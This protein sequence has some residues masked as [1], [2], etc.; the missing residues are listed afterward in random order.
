MVKTLSIAVLLAFSALP[1]C[2]AVEQS[3]SV[4]Q[5]LNAYWDELSRSV[6]KGDMDGLMSLY[7]P[8]AIAREWEGDSYT[9]R[10]AS[11]LPDG[12]VEFH[13]G[14][15]EG[16]RAITLDWRFST[17][18]HDGRVAHEVGIGRFQET[19]GGGQTTTSFAHVE[20]YLV[21]KDRWLTTLESVRWNATEAEWNALPNRR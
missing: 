16:L 15:K 7:H 20:Q 1:A 2:P 19:P 11:S 17:R 21:K 10:L 12:E 9:V 4:I 18:I 13:K 5:E 3:D 14:T 6:T 8:D